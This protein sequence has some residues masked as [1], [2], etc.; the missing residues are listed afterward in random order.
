MFNYLV[1]H[2]TYLTIKQITGVGKS[3]TIKA[4]AMHGEKI[5]R[6]EGNDPN[7]PNVIVCAFTG[8]AASLI[9][10]LETYLISR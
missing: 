10:K 7:H 8:K 1:T 6:K 2:T 3:E 9:G 4:L 5:L